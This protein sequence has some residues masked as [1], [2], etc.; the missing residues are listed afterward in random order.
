MFTSTLRLPKV[1]SDPNSKL[2]ILNLMIDIDLDATLVMETYKLKRQVTCPL[3]MPICTPLHSQYTMVEDEEVKCQ[4]HL[5]DQQW[6]A[7]SSY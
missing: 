6:E 4:K 3:P 5:A 2:K 1:S 7:H